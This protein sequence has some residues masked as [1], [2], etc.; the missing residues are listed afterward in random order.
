VLRA[1]GRVAFTVWA[2]PDQHA[3]QGI[4]LEAA[5]SAGDIG[6]GLPTPPH[7]GLN[8]IEACVALLSRAGL[9]P[10]TELCRLERRT[11]RLRSVAELTHLIES[12]TV[13]LASLLRSQPSGKRAAI[14]RGLEL[15]ANR[16][17]R[18]GNL[19]IPVVAV[20]VAATL[21]TFQSEGDDA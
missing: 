18:D 1:S 17:R 4:A 11:L 20:L 5:R 16:Y 12:G 7:G 19:E 2:T 9:S 21:G 10:I 13:R 15:A 8:T 6:A 3:L 14:L